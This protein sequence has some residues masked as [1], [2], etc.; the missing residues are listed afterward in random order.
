MGFSEL[1][2]EH[3]VED[4]TYKLFSGDNIELMSPNELKNI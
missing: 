2:L 4:L 1:P 3:I